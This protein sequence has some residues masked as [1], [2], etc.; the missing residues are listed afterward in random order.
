MNNYE[1]YLEC[2]AA[3]ESAGIENF[4]NEARWLV[5]EPF[6]LS[7]GELFSAAPVPPER[8]GK[9]RELCRNRCQHQPLQYLL[10]SAPFGEIELAVTPEVLIPRCETEV[11]VD[12]A[13]AHLP[14]GARLLDV[15]CGSG[16]IALL[17]AFRRRDIQVTAVDKSP[18]ALEVARMNARRLELP[19]IPEFLESDLL[20]ALE[21][22]RFDFIAANLP[23]VTYEEYG[24]LS[25]EV[26]EYEPQMALVA[27]DDGMAL[28][29]QL[30]A[31]APDKLADNGWLAL[32]MSPHQ[33]AR[34]EAEMT[35]R[36]FEEISVFAD[37]FGKKRF[38]AGV[39]RKKT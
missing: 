10:G 12:F 5:L 39:Y 29:S 13:L 14:E 37:Q 8:L 22:R 31:D 7:A 23:Y 27:A 9:V 38:A 3:L 36:G 34:A 25:T 20:S 1:L 24:T 32:E 33:T 21:G 6:Q 4:R 26:R 15:G 2:A 16:A 28:I 17:A 11:L 19:D 30:I 18:G 35:R